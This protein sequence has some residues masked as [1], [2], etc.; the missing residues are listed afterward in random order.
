MQPIADLT[1]IAVHG[2]GL[3]HQDIDDN[4]G[5]QFLGKLVGAVVVRAVRD[6]GREAVGL[7]IGAHQ[8]IRPGLAGG[9]RRIRRV[10]GRLVERGI[11]G[12]ERTVHLVG[13]DVMKAMLG[14]CGVDPEGLGGLEQYMRTDHIGADEIIG[15]E[16][17]TIDMRFGGEMH[18]GIDVGA[19]RAARTA[20][21]SQMSPG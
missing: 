16:N 11:V 13:R 10:R 2:Q 18:Q 5:D 17:G 21:S 4:E 19:S 8:V 7:V 20:P 1:S 14:F 3:A 9:V 15:P 6:R 12:L